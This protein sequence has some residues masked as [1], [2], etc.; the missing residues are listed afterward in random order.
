MNPSEIIREIQESASEW[1]EMS[2]DPAML[3]AVI[4]ADKIIKLNEHIQ[5]LEKRLDYVSAT[6]L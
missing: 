5:Y 3:I 4:L 1:I 6:R 2:E